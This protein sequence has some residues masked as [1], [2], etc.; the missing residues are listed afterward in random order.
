MA[1]D[2]V[3][4]LELDQD[5][6]TDEIPTR[7]RIDQ[8]R[9][10]LATYFI[11]SHFSTAWS[12]NV[13][14]SMAYTEWTARCTDLLLTHSSAKTDALL[15]W[16]VRLQ[17]LTEETHE[18]RK[19]KNSS[20]QT[21]YQVELILKGIESQLNEWETKMPA[22]VLSSRMPSHPRSPTTSQ[23]REKKINN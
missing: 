3:T 4:D 21:T 18:L 15:A 5:P 17:R 14:A 8:I 1:V 10:Y 22:D 9:L 19:L 13:A 11:T 23:T 12:R 6:G 20:P 7:E 2:I 16:K